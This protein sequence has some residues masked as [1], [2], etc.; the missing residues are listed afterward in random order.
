MFAAVQFRTHS[1]DWNVL[2]RPSPALR[3]ERGATAVYG[4]GSRT[5]YNAGRKAKPPSASNSRIR[6]A[7]IRVESAHG[8]F[9]SA[10]NPHGSPVFFSDAA[11][12][13]GCDGRRP[14]RIAGAL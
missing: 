9:A 2:E 4:F 13:I 3:F 12:H 7:H 11:R 6:N 8:D 14:G 10:G 1:R 5:P